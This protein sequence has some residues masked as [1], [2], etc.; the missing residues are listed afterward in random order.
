M[1]KDN[2]I[3]QVEHC[4]EATGKLL[5]CVNEFRKVTE[6]QVNIPKKKNQ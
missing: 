6:Y 2:M 4:K 3:L 5:E 1:F